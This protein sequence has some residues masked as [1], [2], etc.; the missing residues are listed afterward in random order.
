MVVMKDRETLKDIDATLDQ[1]IKNAEALQEVSSDP[2]FV[3][4]VAALSKTQESLLTHLVHLDQFLK[5]KGPKK[6]NRSINDKIS[7]FTELSKD[8]SPRSKKHKPQ[9]SN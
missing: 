7:L 2:L 6:I 1:L 8:S 5:Q 3:E 4:E 9:L